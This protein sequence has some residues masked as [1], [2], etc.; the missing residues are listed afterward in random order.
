MDSFFIPG[1]HSPKSSPQSSGLWAG[2][3]IKREAF[4]SLNLTWPVHLSDPSQVEAQV[5]PLRSPRWPRSPYLSREGG[6]SLPHLAGTALTSST[7]GR[8]PQ[9]G[10]RRRPRSCLHDRNYS[11]LVSLSHVFALTYVVASSGGTFG[12]ATLFHA[13][14]PLIWS[15]GRACWH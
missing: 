12:Q 1:N 14:A 10:R 11:R 9:D 2:S 3:D 7:R 6:R 4:F 13:L 5:K 15:V 8:G